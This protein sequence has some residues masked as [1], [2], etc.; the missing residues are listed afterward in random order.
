MEWLAGRRME[1]SHDKT[2]IVVTLDFISQ[3]KIKEK[4]G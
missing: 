3:K 1:F 4:L 2:N